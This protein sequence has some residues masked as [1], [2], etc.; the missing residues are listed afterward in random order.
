ML[1]ISESR[2]ALSLGQSVTQ[3]VKALAV[4]NSPEVR[5]RT[6]EAQHEIQSRDTNLTNEKLS[7]SSLD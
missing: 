5:G 3:L 1:L 4:G 6:Y 7:I 2:H